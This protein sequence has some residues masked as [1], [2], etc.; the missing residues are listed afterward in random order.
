MAN[1]DTRLRFEFVLRLLSS[2]WFLLP[3]FMSSMRLYF[4]LPNEFG[5]DSMMK[6]KLLFEC[7]LSKWESCHLPRNLSHGSAFSLMDLSG[8]TI[9]NKFFFLAILLFLPPSLNHKPYFSSSTSLAYNLLCIEKRVEVP[10]LEETVAVISVNL[11][12]VWFIISSLFD[13]TH[14]CLA[15]E[16]IS[17]L[18]KDGRHF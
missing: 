12:C 18:W 1:S 6:F 16:K 14:L 8:L 9:P 4:W 17:V 3:I 13:T 2:I 7:V 15:K 11:E 10:L 5:F